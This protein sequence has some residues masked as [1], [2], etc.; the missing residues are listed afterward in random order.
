F[1]ESGGGARPPARLAGI[2]AS[3]RAHALVR[4]GALRR[5][6]EVDPG[7]APLSLNLAQGL[8]GAPAAAGPPGLYPG[9][10]LERSSGRAAGPVHPREL[11]AHL[12]KKRV[13]NAWGGYS[14]ATKRALE[15]LH[16]RGLVR[17]ARREQGVRVYQIVDAP[18][19]LGSPDQRL[20]ALVLAVAQVF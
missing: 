1:R 18:V 10:V 3:H 12:G 13:L 11:A 14:Q 17:I 15:R 4:A 5:V 19:A 16:H 20:R 8:G 9:A 7:A 2:S 6:R